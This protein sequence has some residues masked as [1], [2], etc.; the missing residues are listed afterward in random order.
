M[1]MNTAMRRFLFPLAAFVAGAI[2]YKYQIFPFNLA[3]KIV[4]G[5]R[6]N[7]A[8]IVAR[9]YEPRRDHP[10]TT[11]T[12]DTGLLP[13][14]IKTT[15]VGH[16]YD[17]ANHGGSICA[18]ADK[19]L[20]VNRLGDFYSYEGGAVHKV[21]L[22][23]APNHLAEFA[24][25][26]KYELDAYNFRVHDCMIREGRSAS[27]LF[28]TYERFEPTTKKTNFALASI[29]IG[30]KGFE[31]KSDWT[32]RFESKPLTMIDYSGQAAGGRMALLGDQK[33]LFSVGSYNQDGV[34]EPQVVSQDIRGDYGAV[35]VLDVQS[36]S[37]KK[38]S[39]GHRN[40]QG[41]TVAR[42]G[43]I[44]ETEHGP[45]GGDEVNILSIGPAPQNY[46]YPIETLGVDY[47]TY[48]WPRQDVQGRHDRYIPPIF[49][50]V[51]S[52]GI[53]NL[54]EAR[55]FDKRWDGDLLVSSLK[56]NS[57]FRLRLSKD[58]RSVIYSEPIWI[59]DRIRNI[60][61][62]QGKIFLWT[63]TSK[64]IEIDVDR[65]KLDSNV[66]YRENLYS[67]TYAKCMLCHHSGDTIPG[68]MAPSLSH[69][70][71]RKIGADSFDRYSP[72]MKTTSGYW[73]P[74]KLRAFLIDS[75]SVIKGTTMPKQALTE[76]ELDD[77]I[78]V[79]SAN[80]N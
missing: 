47:G 15:D 74:E 71:G 66:S 23:R 67:K 53:S 3:S 30:N 17:A 1:L 38:I 80:K 9:Q 43:V 61:Q 40:T 12:I 55:S 18:L 36:N 44:Y 72:A 7:A 76:K 49:A 22:E 37:I 70:V 78:A 69:I 29:E 6:R 79:L 28:L 48:S 56:G 20:I 39:Y 26:S 4:F 60:I 65:S 77:I 10:Q 34:I 62:R 27:T 50:F 32:L 8:K 46:G 16:F 41:L 51:P 64:I 21:E 42:N 2:F 57:L 25:T 45:Q 33:L 59:G 19:L 14:T 5:I 68:H 24:A 63:D 58:G 73:T 11:K 52:I 75:E 31:K 13:L 35:F 54:I